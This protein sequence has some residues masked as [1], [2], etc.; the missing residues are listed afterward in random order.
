[1]SQQSPAARYRVLPLPIVQKEA[2]KLLT[3][4]QLVEGISLTKQLRHYPD[5]PDLSIEPCGDGMELRLAGQAIDRQGWLRAIFWIY[6]VKKTIYIVD[7]FW[8]KSN[9]VS[10]ADMHRIN[11]RIRQLKALLAGG[12]QPWRSGH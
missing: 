9:R 7:L 1:M 5:V 12:D 6:D 8:K 4:Q 2:R 11:F 10:T 3:A